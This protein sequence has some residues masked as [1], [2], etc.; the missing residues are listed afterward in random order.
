MR[1]TRW[2]LAA[3]LAVLGFSM[4]L[5]ALASIA[6][7]FW[8]TWELQGGAAAVNEAGRMRMQAYRLALD[9]QLGADSDL[10]RHVDRFDESLA[11][12]RDGD[13]S[14]PLFVPWNDATRER[15][16]DVQA[17]WLA[18][19]SDWLSRPDLVR[20]SRVDGFVE[21]TDAFVASI[22]NQLSRWTAILYAY[23][24]A[25][26]A[27]AIAGAVALLYTG[28]IYVVDPV[29]RLRRALARVEQGEFDA[30]VAVVA[31][32]EFGELGESFNRMAGNLQQLYASL[33]DKVRSE[34][35]TSE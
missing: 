2:S 24:F 9:A 8:V 12:L 21:S 1:A 22:E 26:M 11:V 14:R 32:D 25:M 31:H 28:Y 33:E 15:F 4:L 10:S 3:R 17:Q 35:H 5:L 18:L 6:L 19:R 34:E 30:R 20:L 29:A 13:P 23:Q 27:L 16:D 7:T